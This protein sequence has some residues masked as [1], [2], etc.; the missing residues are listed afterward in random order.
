MFLLL[1]WADDVLSNLDQK[2]A[3]V[4][5]Q[6]TVFVAADGKVIYRIQT[7]NR[8]YLKL[9]DIPKVVKDAILA[10][11]DKRFY[12][13]SGYDTMGLGRAVFLAAREGHTAGG[14]S[15]ITMQLAKRLYS[16]SQ[17]TMQRKLQDI[18]IAS[19]MEKRL[20][21]DQILELY[22]N[23]VYFGEG[24][25]GVGAAAEV[26]FGKSV[27]K[28]NLAEAAMLSRCVRRPSADNPIFDYERSMRNK[29]VV[30]TVMLDE[31]MIDRSEF[32]EAVEERPKLNP[33]KSKTTAQVLNAPY[34]VQHVRR[35]I[36]ADLPNIDLEDG[37]YRIETTL[38]SDLQDL[39]E[40]QV[41]EIVRRYRRQGV[42]TG[43][44]VLMDGQGR[45]LAEVG[46]EDYRKEQ[47]NIIT[48][49]N[50]RQPGSAFKPFVYSAALASGTLGPNDRVD[51]HRRVFTDPSTHR[52]YSPRNHGRSFGGGKVSLDIALKYSL[53]Q[54]AVN[55]LA[56]TGIQTVV[57]YAR[58]TFGFPGSRFKSVGA[59]SYSMALGTYEVLPL[60]M[61]QAY[62]V[63]MTGGDRVQ[64][65]PVVRVLGPTGELIKRYD[66][67]V[68]RGVLDPTVAHE[69]D[70]ALREVVEGGTGT[71]ARLVPDAHGKTGTTQEGRD[72]WFCGYTTNL[73]G[74]SW[75]ANVQHRNGRP[76]YLPMPDVYGGSVPIQ[77]WAGVMKEA[78]KKYGHPI[79]SASDEK[80]VVAPPTTRPDKAFASPEQLPGTGDGN[81]PTKDA[82]QPNATQDTNPPDD[83]PAVPTQDPP[84]QPAD[85]AAGNEN[86]MVE[87]EIC[88][89]SG[90]RAGIYCPETVTKLFPR[91]KVPKRTCTVHKQ[92][93]G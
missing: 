74:I 29:K 62:S 3:D 44:F 81:S 18:A 57:S 49:G 12:Q 83:N 27:Q 32:D 82:G 40:Q 41:S 39:A 61:C 90:M 79:E 85:P 43:A 23:Q 88:A 7:E 52:T 64:P 11:E 28:L 15:T 2:L 48:Q 63:F 26:Y 76:Y 20:T 31:G 75:V 89:D 21:K 25:H 77:V 51:N 84:P 54:A 38:D 70:G 19:T 42:T 66:A 86:D 9:Q 22:L 68:F 16:G 87:V 47:F 55:T 93:G 67:M 24:A 65:R 5:K 17:Q 92:P 33:K 13:H 80:A 34:F 8:A 60:E 35:F 56:D 73:V 10:A 59:F 91:N 30:L 58:D 71:I 45:V 1:K 72:A 46:G 50:G 14:G 6:P 53:N 69:V 36:E 78:Y 37:G 4:A